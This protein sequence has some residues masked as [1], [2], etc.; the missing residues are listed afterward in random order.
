MG[1]V[2]AF[3][4]RFDEHGHRWEPW[5]SEA[6]IARHFGVT[7]R[8][9]RKWRLNGLPSRRVEGSRRYRLSQVDAWLMA[10]EARS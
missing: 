5:I 8:T 3:P 4:A 1:S 10:R 7:T 9:V 2:I 6:A